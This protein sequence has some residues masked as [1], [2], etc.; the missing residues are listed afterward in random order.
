MS[1]QKKRVPAAA[2]DVLDRAHLAHYTMENSALEREIIELF[3][4]QLPVTLANLKEA[5][6]QTEWKL[7]THTL[8]GSAAA[9]G[10]TR[11]NGIAAELE[12][13]VFDVD[14]KVSSELIAS[15][16]K[17]IGQFCKMAARIYR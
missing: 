2:A 14:V 3:L 9:V 16:E 10:A 12:T 1:P 5:S 15:L 7:A 8:K 4:S 11:I 6:N 13:L 17:A